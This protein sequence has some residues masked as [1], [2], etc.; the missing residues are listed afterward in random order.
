MPEGAESYS[1]A[2]AA[3][4]R[5]PQSVDKAEYNLKATYR[6]A[7]RF[8]RTPQRVEEQQLPS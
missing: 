2:K 3:I 6:Q 1:K 8:A 4:W 7:R 5:P